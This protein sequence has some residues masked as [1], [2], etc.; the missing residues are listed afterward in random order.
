MANKNRQVLIAYFPNDYAADTAAQSLKAWDKANDAVKLGGVGILTWQDGKMKTH[1]VGAHAAGTGAKWGTILGATLG[2]LSGGVTLIGGV[3]AGATAGAVGGALVHKRIGLTD[4]DKA[5]ME[6]HVKNGGA[7][8]VVMADDFEVEPTKAELASLG[9]TV[10]A[11]Q[12]PEEHAEEL[13]AA[14][15]EAAP[16]EATPTAEAAPAAEAGASGDQ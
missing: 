16:A 4:E 10:E 7:V 14:P 2:I 15:A 1:K 8:V 3:L 11:Y 9:G 12:V 13:E 6:E 5:R